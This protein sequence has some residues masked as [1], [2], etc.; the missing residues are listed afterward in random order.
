MSASLRQPRAFAI[1]PPAAARALPLRLLPAVM[2]TL[3]ALLPE[4]LNIR[5]A[6]LLLTTPR[7]VLLASLP[8]MLS[9][10]S[11]RFA[12]TGLRLAPCDWAMC[13]AA[14]WMFLSVS[15][16]QGLDRAIV[17]ASVLILELCGSYCLIRCALDKPGD[18]AI[19]TR[20]AAI[21]IAANGVLSLADIVAGRH[22]L[23]DM[24]QAVTGYSKDW[25][26][27]YRNGILRS[28]GMQ[29]HPILLGTVSVCGAALALAACKGAARVV[30]CAG[31][32][33]GVASANS[34]APIGAFVLVCL[35][36]GY[37]AVT[38]NFA[39][40][41]HVLMA[42]SGTF[43]ALLFALHPRPF[44]FILDHFTASPQ[45]GYYRLL[46]WSLCGPLVLDSPVYGLGLESDFAERFG[47]AQ[48]V[49]SVWLASAMNFGLPGA[50]LL[51]AV[52]IL[53]CSRPVRRAVALPEGQETR[54]GLALGIIVFLYIYLGLTVDF[55]GCTWIFMGVFA[56]MRVH[57]GQPL[58]SP[59]VRPR[60]G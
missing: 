17:G 49:D 57:M 31:C 60:R 15:M 40:R 35:L 44:S 25:R 18:A 13:A 43:L 58:A 37:R 21:F 8:F 59:P 29:E 38:P 2:L 52:L 7:I 34:S 27:D 14:A 45:D 46:I 23:H 20:W 54:I 41:W 55:W 10:L 32:L 11:R 6:G 22:I 26:F 5:P 3:C 50:V 9:Q 51:A 28:Q 33:A 56:A 1:A 12:A 47:V 19:L 39:R 30:L 16:T 42:A 4:D 48:T 36:L 53:S 24:A